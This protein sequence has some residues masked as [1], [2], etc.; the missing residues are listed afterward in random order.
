MY[1]VQVNPDHNTSLN[2]WSSF[3]EV[4]KWLHNTNEITCPEACECR[5]AWVGSTCHAAVVY[6]M[7]EGIAEHPEW[8]PGLTP[9]SSFEEFQDYL[10]RW[11]DESECTKPCMSYPKHAP[12]T[13]F[14]WS[15]SRNSG[16][17]A[18]I[19]RNQLKAGAGIFGC[20]GFAVV[21]ESEWNVGWGPGERIGEVNAV[22]F[23]GAGVGTSKDGTAANAELFMNAWEVVL[24][25]THVMKFDWIIKVDPDSVVVADRLRDHFR[26]W[27]G[28]KVFVRNCNKFPME[29]E[30]PMMFG[31]LEAISN[32]A[33]AVYK[34]EAERCK[35]E[36][37]WQPWGEDFFLGKCLPLLG[38]DPVDDFTVISDGVCTDVN[39]FDSWSAAFHPFKSAEDWMT[40]WAAATSQGGN[41][42]PPL[43]PLP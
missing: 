32:A 17:E 40:C 27:S 34:N 39:C 19:M 2:N 36:L 18:D 21:S 24:K 7:E 37:D 28:K 20:D 41:Q 9:K 33:L 13:L 23:N 15:V 43:P 1:D 8:Y 14:C 10:W 31:S 30:F 6:A 11:D 29:A 35:T 26:G 12:P 38:V 16:Y 25:K 22:I 42:G 3:E 4:Q 5:P